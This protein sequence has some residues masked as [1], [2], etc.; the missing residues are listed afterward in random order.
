M[1]RRVADVTHRATD[2]THR[3]PSLAVR[4]RGRDGTGR[5]T[6]PARTGSAGRGGLLTVVRGAGPVARALAGHP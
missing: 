5:T 2:V 6:A 3:A 4:D 1:T